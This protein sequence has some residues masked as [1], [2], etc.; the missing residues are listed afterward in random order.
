M[1]DLVG[2]ISFHYYYGT[3]SWCTILQ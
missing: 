3:V 1:K 2:L